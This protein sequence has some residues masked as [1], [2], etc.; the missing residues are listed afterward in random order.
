[1]QEYTY[2]TVINWSLL[3][4]T[5]GTMANKIIQATI[6]RT[7]KLPS[8]RNG[9]RR[10]ALRPTY[11]HLFRIDWDVQ[12]V[13]V[14]LDDA[15]WRAAFSNA[16]VVRCHLINGEL[17]DSTDVADGKPYTALLADEE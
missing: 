16:A 11:Y 12:S 10:K 3:N 13:P 9:I 8:V 5:K 2:Y 7:L 6:P 4:L 14:D 15:A 17:V 1:M